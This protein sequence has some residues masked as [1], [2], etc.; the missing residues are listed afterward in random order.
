MATTQNSSVYQKSTKDESRFPCTVSRAILHSPSN[1]TSG[2]TSFRQH[3]ILCKDT[4]PSLEEQQIQHSNSRKLCVPQILSEL[5]VIIWLRLKRNPHFPQ[6]PQEEDS[7]SYRY[8]SGTRSLLPQ[9]KGPRD[10]LTQKR[11]GLPCSGSNAGSSFSTEEVW[12]SEP[13]VEN[14]DKALGPCLITRGVLTSLL[15][16]ESH[17]EFNASK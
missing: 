12:M 7:L 10:V 4:V 17:S 16:I 8:V 3:Q 13:D 1:I 15:Q 11:D 6:A 2:L 9:R 5:E 14:L